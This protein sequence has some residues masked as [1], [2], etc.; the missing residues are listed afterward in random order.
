MVKES[1]NQGSKPFVVARHEYVRCSYSDF[2]LFK[3][4][5]NIGHEIIQI[6]LVEFTDQELYQKESFTVLEGRKIAYTKWICIEE[7][8]RG[9]KTLFPNGLIELLQKCVSNQM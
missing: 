6:Y 2:L 3:I 1:H 7:I 8:K 5:E 9:K 4:D